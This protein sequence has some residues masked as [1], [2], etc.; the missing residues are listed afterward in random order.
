MVI[1]YTVFEDGEDQYGEAS[2][3]LRVRFALDAGGKL[4][5]GG[6]EVLPWCLAGASPPCTELLNPG[7][8]V[9]LTP[10]IFA[11]HE[12]QTPAQYFSGAFLNIPF[13]D[14]P[15]NILTD[16]VPWPE[17]LRGTAW[18]RPVGVYLASGLAQIT[19]ELD[20]NITE[21]PALYC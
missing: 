16:D 17:L 11:G 10:P 20:Q 1:Y 9:V 5:T 19:T 12:V 15:D 14:S 7:V 4:A 21:P 13:E 8:A 2:F 3:Q 6:I 18:E